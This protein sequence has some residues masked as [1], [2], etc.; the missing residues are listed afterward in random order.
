MECEEKRLA[1]PQ[2]VMVGG[3]GRNDGK[4]A[5]VC[6][7]IEGLRDRMPVWAVKV[8]CVEKPHQP[9]H[10]GQQ[11]CGLCGGLQGP[12]DI[13]EE[14]ETGTGKDTALMLAAGAKRAFLMRSRPEAMAAAMRDFV[15]HL[16]PGVA[17]VCESNRMRHSVEPGV[18][19]FAA[20]ANAPCE[21]DKPGAEA[22]AKLAQQVVLLGQAAPEIQMEKTAQGDMR[23]FL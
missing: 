16:P 3:F 23:L 10:R 9:C 17:V 11:G 21:T 20:S 5:L 1:L 13:R 6:T 7:V 15:K 19:L 8:I 4:T 2:M 14:N 12:F 18:F 22:L